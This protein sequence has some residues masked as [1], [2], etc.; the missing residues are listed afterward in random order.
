MLHYKNSKHYKLFITFGTWSVIYETKIT[1]HII[2]NG[3]KKFLK[4]ESKFND[5]FLTHYIFTFKSFKS[6]LT[7]TFLD[8][9]N[10]RF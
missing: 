8:L 10:N 4:R 7:E 3:T 1:Q 5:L 9:N 2:V 6:F